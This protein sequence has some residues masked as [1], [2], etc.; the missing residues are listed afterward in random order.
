MSS[1]SCCKNANK[2][3]RTGHL[4]CL[5]A[6]CSKRGFTWNSKHAKEACLIASRHGHLDCLKY[7]HQ[8]GCPIDDFFEMEIEGYII[9]KNVVNTAIIGGHLD[10]LKYA[11]KEA[12]IEL[13]DDDAY[14]AASARGRLNCLEYLRNEGFEWYPDT[15][16]I[17]AR[18]GHF[19]CL[20]YAFENGAP[21]CNAVFDVLEDIG[22]FGPD[23]LAAAYGHLECLKYFCEKEVPQSLEAIYYAMRFNQLDCAKYLIA[24]GYSCVVFDFWMQDNRLDVSDL[25]DP[26]WRHFLL[27]VALLDKAPLVR[28]V[29]DRK[30]VEIQQTKEACMCLIPERKMNPDILKYITYLYI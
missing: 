3:A 9:E 28:E 13:I 1:S 21:Y 4:S 16:A 26:V 12:G 18:Y 2:A 17:C 10:C 29:V 14:I 15:I 23:T 25:D 5:Q 30:K 11:H 20:R 8:R 22:E 7:A 27:D 19:D 6:I 24:Q